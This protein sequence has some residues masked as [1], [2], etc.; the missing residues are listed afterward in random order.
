MFEYSPIPCQAELVSANLVS[1]TTDAGKRAWAVRYEELHIFTDSG[2]QQTKPTGRSPRGFNTDELLTL[3]EAIRRYNSLSEDNIDQV[4]I[5]G[6]R[7]HY[8]SLKSREK[9][10]V[11]VHGQ[12]TLVHVDVGSGEEE[13]ACLYV[14]KTYARA[15]VPGFQKLDRPS[16]EQRAQGAHL[17]N[18][19]VS[20]L[21]CNDGNKE[22]NF[23][24]G[25]QLLIKA[26]ELGDPVAQYNVFRLQQGPLRGK[27][28]D[29]EA[30]RCLRAAAEGGLANAYTSLGDVYA[31]GWLGQGVDKNEAFDCYS[32]AV[33]L[34][35]WDAI[36]MCAGL[37]FEVGGAGPQTLAQLYKLG[38]RKGN[39]E[40]QEMLNTVFKD[41]A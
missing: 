10:E 31:F 2:N 40:C 37:L 16:P 28:S 5:P 23:A 21:Q 36:P 17:F 11:E 22:E 35:D 29:A 1:D 12:K 26:A 39:Q 25:C 8:V 4:A 19:A 27:I 33:A 24:R 38:A 34:G 7:Y 32:H 41:L 6:Q 20:C 13:L 15:G 14:F 9:P 18:E 30:L 3:D